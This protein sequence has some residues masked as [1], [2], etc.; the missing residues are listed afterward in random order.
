MALVATAPRHRSA[1]VPVLRDD[2]LLLGSFVPLDPPAGGSLPGIAE[3]VRAAGPPGAVVLA[4][5][6]E[7]GSLE[8][9]A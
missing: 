6:F 9:R 7:R 1:A 8:R 4:V 2:L 5:R 3:A